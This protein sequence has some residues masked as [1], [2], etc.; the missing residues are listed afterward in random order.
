MLY[1]VPHAR[2][3]TRDQLEALLRTYV[4]AYLLALGVTESNTQ[5]G[6]YDMLVAKTLA[7]ACAVLRRRKQ[8]TEFGAMWELLDGHA[9]RQTA[10]IADVW[11]GSFRLGEQLDACATYHLTLLVR[12]VLAINAPEAAILAVTS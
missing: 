12:A 11:T 9:A 5:H 3:E 7:F 2:V 6:A 10:N 1:A 4:E 8:A